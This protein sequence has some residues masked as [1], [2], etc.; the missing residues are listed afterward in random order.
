MLEISRVSFFVV[1]L[2]VDL[3]HFG[4]SVELVYTMIENGG[5]LPNAK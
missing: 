5:H 1:Y 3:I 4:L 2:M